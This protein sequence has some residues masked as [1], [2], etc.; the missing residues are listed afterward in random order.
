[1]RKSLKIPRGNHMA[2]F[3]EV[4]TIQWVKENGLRNRSIKHST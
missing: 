3:E 2:E 4:Q 1:M